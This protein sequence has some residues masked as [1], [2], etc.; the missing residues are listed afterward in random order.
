[1]W[2]SSGPNVR[3]RL[4][5][6]FPAGGKSRQQ[7]WDGNPLHVHIVRPWPQKNCAIRPSV[8]MPRNHR[9]ASRRSRLSEYWRARERHVPSGPDAA[10]TNGEP[11]QHETGPSLKCS[12]AP[13]SF[14]GGL[15]AYSV[16]DCSAATALRTSRSR[17]RTR[18]WQLHRCARRAFSGVVR[19][20][21]S[22]D[23]LAA[24][25]MRASIRRASSRFVRCRWCR[26][27]TRT[28]MALLRPE[29]PARGSSACPHDAP[30]SQADRGSGAHSFLRQP[31]T[32]A[33]RK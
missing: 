7:S 23:S 22:S 30:T 17:R 3:A 11:D 9:T 10:L 26:P 24:A 4:C 1:M 19:A 13:A 12:S 16:W 31:R 2:C 25:R 27:S 21:R 15:H 29:A 33:R 14:P 5:A 18:G 20:R 6:P 28:R 32:Q 8:R